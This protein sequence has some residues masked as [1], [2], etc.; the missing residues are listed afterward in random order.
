MRHHF[1]STQLIIF[2]EVFVGLTSGW[3]GSAVILP[4][5]WQS[6]NLTFTQIVILLFLQIMFG[7][8]SLIIAIYLREESKYAN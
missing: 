8:V 1:N 2:S 4:G 5:I 6:V 7:I 3:V